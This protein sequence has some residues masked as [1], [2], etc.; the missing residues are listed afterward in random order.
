[1]IPASV[2]LPV[3]RLHAGDCANMAERIDVLFGAK[4][5]G[6]PRNIVLH[7]GEEERAR[8]GLCQITLAPC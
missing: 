5:H 8:C 3:T 6:D 4:T 7:W 1:M 2:N